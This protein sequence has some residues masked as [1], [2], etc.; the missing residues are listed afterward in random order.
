LRGARPVAVGIVEKLP[1][2]RVVDD[3]VI[4]IVAARRARGGIEARI[5][6]SEATA[7]ADVGKGGYV[8]L[9]A[10]PAGVERADGVGVGRAEFAEDDAVLA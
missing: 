4:R 8:E 5:P 7:S 10:V 3:A 9:D 1:R 6:G 2:A